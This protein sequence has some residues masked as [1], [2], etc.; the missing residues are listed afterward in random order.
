MA[1]RAIDEGLDLS[2]EDGLALEQDLFEEVFS[3]DDALTARKMAAVQEW[4][5]SPQYQALRSKR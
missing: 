4:F 2:L 3:T 1:K 5:T